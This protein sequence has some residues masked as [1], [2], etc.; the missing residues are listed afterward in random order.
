[1]LGEV[2][3]VV[4]ERA[5]AGHR[6][7]EAL[8]SVVLLDHGQEPVDVG[9]ALDG[10]QRGVAV[11][12]D[13][14]RIAGRVVDRGA[15]DDAGRLALRD[16][17]VDEGLELGAVDGLRLRAD[18]DQ[19]VDAVPVGR[20]PRAEQV[21]RPLRLR[22]P[23]HV[24]VGGQ[25]P[26]KEHGSRGECDHDRTDP[27]AEDTPRMAA[28]R[29]REPLGQAH[30]AQYARAGRARA[31]GVRP[32]TPEDACWPHSPAAAWMRS[33]SHQDHEGGTDVRHHRHHQQL[34]RAR[35]PG[36][37]RPRG[38]ALLERL[39]RP[40]EGDRHPPRHGSRRAARRRPRQT[41]WRRSTTRSPTS[42]PRSTGVA[43]SP[44]PE[45]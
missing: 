13:Q 35:R 7:V 25:V 17:V 31:P 6:D 45:R 40:R 14:P 36:G 20:E 19:L 12:G 9:L 33:W 18:D 41:R 16:E 4:V 15:V 38:Q 42:A 22:R 43:W 2:V 10:D 44:R 32:A 1:M 29:A 34:G 39:R 27:G 21:F 26:G 30:L 28:R 37:R 11:L 5:L 3:E 24:P 8:P 23:G